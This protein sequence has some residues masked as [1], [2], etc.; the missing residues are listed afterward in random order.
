MYFFLKIYLFILER[1]HECAQVVGVEGEGENL[2]QTSRWAQLRARPK[3]PGAKTVRCSANCATE[4]PW[5]KI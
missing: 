5:A 4:A 1:E 2:K 3:D